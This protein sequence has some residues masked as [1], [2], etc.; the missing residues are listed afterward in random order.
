MTARVLAFSLLM[1]VIGSAGCTVRYSQSLA[2]T[3]P[4]DAGSDVRSSDA[5]FSL[6]SITLSEPTHAHE[7]VTSLMGACSKLTKVEVDYREL[8]FLLFGLPRVT[9]TGTCLR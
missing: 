8:S 6:L 2:G 1:I 3:I 5:G 9:V 7:Q 4:G